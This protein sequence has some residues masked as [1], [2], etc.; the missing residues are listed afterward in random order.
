MSKILSYRRKFIILKDDMTNISGIRP[1]GHAKIE[2]KGNKGYVNVNVESSEIGEKYQVFLIG[3]KNKDIVDAY[4]GKIFTNEK[5]KGRINSNFNIKNVKN[6]GL[7]IGEFDGIIIRKGIGILLVGYIN[8]NSKT[9]KRYIEKID[10]D[11]PKESKL[12]ENKEEIQEKVE[13]KNIVEEEPLET[14]EQFKDK[15]QEMLEPEQNEDKSEEDEKE[16]E[17]IEIDPEE[18]KEEVE[19]MEIEEEMQDIE[20]EEVVE[21]IEVEEIKETGEK[22]QKD[23]EEAIEKVENIDTKEN[24]QECEQESYYE[25][26]YCYKNID[27]IRKLNYKNKLTNYVLSILKFFPYIDP[28][29]LKLK[30]Y[31]WWRIEYDG[32][33][34]YRGFLPFYNCLMDTSYKYPLMGNTVTCFQ[35]M[36]K[37]NHYLFGM[38]KEKDEV[39]YY[40]YAVPGKFTSMEHPFRG[41]TGFNTWFD[42]NENFGYWLIYID[43]LNGKVVFPL[44]PMIPFN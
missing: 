32:S 38:Y 4:L 8:E 17:K 7:S 3:E 25:N 29:K 28:F 11:I 20:I 10:K 35:L 14:E 23:I 37:Y 30:G 13:E 33:H 19:D 36:K 43:P 1:K 27:Y 2:V 18:S 26:L 31:D 34:G 6:T 12:E 42:S 40:L 24:T 21:E 41:L 22:L 44:N 39:K 5:G 9:M 16:I 15:E